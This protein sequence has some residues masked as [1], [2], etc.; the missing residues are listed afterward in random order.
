[1][2]VLAIDTAFAACQVA[3]L[4]AEG[5]VL[6]AASSR[7]A[8]GQAEALP[9]LLREA[10]AAAECRF[11]DLSLIAAT[12][13]PGSFTGVRVAVAAARGLALVAGCPVA[14]I[15][16]LEALARAAPD[17]AKAEGAE[18][19]AVIEARRGQVYA[20]RFRAGPRPQPLEE[21]RVCALADLPVDA[22]PAWAAGD[23]AAAAV[24]AG[25][26]GAAVAGTELPR[27]DHV[28]QLALLDLR[29]AT[30]RPPLPLYVRGPGADGPA[31]APGAA[32]AAAEGGQAGRG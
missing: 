8:R 4:S 11:A 26:A 10:M 32:G 17:A 5:V 29:T 19:L 20:Q 2:T 24:A 18:M 21:A 23:A 22:P 31:A 13:G 7:M 1:M 9:A 30:L 25:R 12:V 15:T 28:A 16:T 3:V 27:P 6:A 14:G